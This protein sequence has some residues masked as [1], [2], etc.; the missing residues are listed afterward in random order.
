M[1][2]IGLWILAAVLV[3]LVLAAPS[4]AWQGRMAGLG[5]AGGLVEDASD[6]LIHPAAIASGKGLNFYGNYRLTYEK[7]TRWDYTLKLPTIPD[8]FAYSSDGKMVK[9]ELQAGTDF[10]A[11][12]GRMGIFLEYALARGKYD[13]MENFNFGAVYNRAFMDMTDNLDHL[14]AR[15]IYG[16]PVHGVKLGGELRIA[17]RRDEQEIFFS[18]F[19]MKNYPWSAENLPDLNLYPYLIPHKSK[20]WEVQ[21]KASVEGMMGQAKYAFTLKGGIPF[22]SDNEYE[23]TGGPATKAN[24]GGNVRGF[25]IG[26]DL[27]IR[28]PVSGRCELPFVVGAGYETRK[29]DGA[30]V[31]SWL[32]W[33]NYENE[34]KN[35]F[36]KIGGGADYKPAKGTKMAAGLYYD[37]LGAKQNISFLD[38]ITPPAVFADYYNDMP[39]YSEHRLTL[40]TLAEKEWSSVVDLRCGVDVFYGSVKS[41]YRY[42]ATFNGLPFIP[43]DVA[44]SGSNMGV[45]ASVGA[46]VKFGG[47]SVE[48]F[49]HAGYAKY[50]ASGR[51]TFNP[52]PADLEFN[53]TNWMISG[54][55]SV[56]L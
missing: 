10:A 40:K 27:W 42:A 9:N 24:A 14:A 23:Y 47:L 15:L 6:Y 33:T 18:S 19:L 20:Y 13:G 44:T 41:D 46:T 35:A 8:V 55:L 4:A 16:L 53:K 34:N 39:E 54:G 43:L 30:G 32:S 52:L 37:F 29:R 26:G 5:D 51:G 12:A 45:N 36:V 2:N 1:K 50:E 21:G 25:N 31:T 7:S 48:P 11:G 28:V 49:V 56:K 17:Y 38:I 3:G 22:G